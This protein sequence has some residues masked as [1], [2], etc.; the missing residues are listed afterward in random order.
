MQ[1]LML[2]QYQTTS[3]NLPWYGQWIIAFSI[4]ILLLYESCHVFFSSIYVAQ[5]FVKIMLHCHFRKQHAPKNV[6]KCCLNGMFL[7][8]AIKQIFALFYL[9]FIQRICLNRRSD[10]LAKISLFH[11]LHSVIHN[12]VF[13]L[14]CKLWAEIRKCCEIFVFSYENIMLFLSYS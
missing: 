6:G 8:I 9:P 4:M 13:A 11:L 10:W 1:T 2:N 14:M 12:L 7:Q 5:N 3:K